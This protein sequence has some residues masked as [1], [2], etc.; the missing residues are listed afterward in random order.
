MIVLICLKSKVI[1]QEDICCI[2]PS[3]MEVSPPY[4]T[5]YTVY[6]TYRAYFAHT[7]YI[8]ST[9]HTVKTV[10]E[11]KGFYGYNYDMCI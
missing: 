5:G 6:T 10:L 8:A 1:I 11:Q 3:E 4:K 9:A 7:A 2:I